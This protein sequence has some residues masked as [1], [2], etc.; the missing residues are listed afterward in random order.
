MERKGVA[1]KKSSQRGQKALKG[2]IG[3]LYRFNGSVYEEA[4][5]EQSPGSKLIVTEEA[6]EAVKTVRK[7][8]QV[9]LR[10]RPE[11]SLVA[12]AMLLEAARMPSLIEAV[13]RY[14]QS[15]YS[16]DPSPA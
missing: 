5:F 4:Q 15:V 2:E 11:L 6:F 1:M 14:G 8:V 12:S 3:K 9:H 10:M 13:K 16:N 7:D